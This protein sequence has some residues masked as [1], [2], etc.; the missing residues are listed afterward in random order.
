[1]TQTITS[2]KYELGR[3]LVQGPRQAVPR[4]AA[5]AKYATG[6]QNQTK[7][8]PASCSGVWRKKKHKSSPTTSANFNILQ[9]NISGIG[10]KKIEL[11]KILDEEKIHVALL[12]ETLHRNTNILITGYTEYPCKC[13]GC[14]GIITYIRNDLTAECIHLDQTDQTDV[15]RTI[16]WYSGKKYKIYNIY[17]P[18]S[19]TCQIDDLQETFYH[20][21][22]VAGD[23]NGHSPQWGYADTDKSGSYLEEL[24]AGTNLVITQNSNSPPTLLHRAHKTLSRPDLTIVSSDL[25]PHCRI[26]VLQ[27]IGSD[28]KAILT[29]VVGKRKEYQKENKVRWNFQKANWSGYRL[30]S[31]EEF[32][33]LNLETSTEDNNTIE[34]KI[35]AIILEAAKKHIP[36]GNAKKYKPFWNQ[37]IQEAVNKRKQAREALEKAPTTSNKI[38]Y[39]RASAEA[40]RATISA[41]R[42]K[43]RSTCATLD[44]RKDGKKAWQLLNNLSG[45]KQ[46]TNPK[47]MPDGETDRKRSEKLNKYFSS[48][49]KSRTDKTNDKGLLKEL[50]EREKIKAKPS[51]IFM[52]P[53]TLQELEQALKSLKMKRSPGPD[54]IHNEMIKHLGT[55]GKK[56]LLHLINTTWE[57]GQLPSAWK[58]AF[59]APIL[60]KDKD[61]TEPKSYRPISLTSCLGKVC[62]R[63]VNR[64]LYWWLEDSN[65]LTEDQAGF[66]ANSRTEDQ[67]FR[68]CQNIQD[69][70][71]EGKHTT[72]VFIDL[73]QAYDRVWRKGL[74][75]KMQRIGIQGR[76]YGWIKSFLSERTIQTKIQNDLSSKQVLEDGLPQGSALSCTLFLIFINDMTEN[77]KSQRALYADDL[78]IWNT[79]KYGLQ[80]ARHLNRDLETLNDYCK[81]WKMTINPT[82]SVHSVFS[83][84]PKAT[85][86]HL[87]IRIDG[88]RVCKADQPV[89]LGVHLDSRLTFKKHIETQKSKTTKRL[90]LIKR[91]TSTNWGSDM[92]TLRTLY[93]GYIRSVLD[94]NQCLLMSTSKTAQTTLDRIQNQALRLICGG[95]KT[96]PTSACEIHA[97]VE[98]LGLRREKATL[99]TFERCSRKPVEH[100]AR[101]LVDKW[102]EKNRIKHRSILHKA[103][104]LREKCPLPGEKAPTEKVN[105]TP[106]NVSVPPPEIKLQLI[107]TEANKKT[108][109]VELKKSAEKTIASYSDRWIHVYTDGSAFKAT[110]NAG[111]GVLICFPDGSSNKIHAACGTI[112]SNYEAEIE[113]IKA[114]VTH[115]NSTFERDP[116]AV[117]NVVIFTD[118]KSAL[119]AMENSNNQTLL[120]ASNLLTAF[121][122]R[123]VLQWIP[124]HTNIEGNDI[125]DKLAKQGANSDQP[126]KPITLQTAKL[127]IK[128][129]YKEEWMNMWARGTTGRAVYNH[130]STTKTKDPIRSLQR[131]E[132]C[133]IF[134][135]RT[136]HVPL[137]SHLNR[138]NPEHAPLC[139]LCDNPNETV[140][141]LLFRCP[142]L[143]DLRLQLLPPIPDVDNSLYSTLEQLQKTAQYYFMALSRRASTHRLLD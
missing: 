119:Q 21:T 59:I 90:A 20:N 14:Q 51:G 131:K 110:I 80:S 106:P 55:C 94:Y 24:H 78:V 6:Y 32:R 96:T 64:R 60:K 67:L 140:E 19:N 30:T 135:L 57:T 10:N 138:I 43:W 50:K 122:I 97:N 139:E 7:T 104:E 45:K 143:Q 49:N 4:Q 76:L 92:V 2:S 126:Q 109:L 65:I 117:A 62:E 8:P 107:D 84:S 18:P 61:P 111:Y 11:A 83:M 137:N 1:M 26:Q 132:Q 41:K 71:Q 44:L 3:R 29:S 81:K 72:A 88:Q 54:K 95:M 79:N 113:G 91:L 87:E 66:R 5:G 86:Q 112:C 23:F 98:P 27:D 82:K 47:P 103:K 133:A 22:V 34:N 53:F 127:I 35:R 15:Q 101:L 74:L 125:A 9:L 118:S 25:E 77:I 116:T 115:L 48:N 105:K 56:A 121:S 16:I 102:R 40:K 99:E 100:P 130:M 13:E 68:L 85:K 124:G 114:A 108:D 39:N 136:Q 120:E 33:K 36:R 142:K 38:N 69:G 31:E 12:Q 123:L 129:N 93:I 28:H 73:Q 141:H 17:S 58:N 128:Q 70:F 134:R 46:R 89:Y 63:M 42:E 52:D 75:L 37:N